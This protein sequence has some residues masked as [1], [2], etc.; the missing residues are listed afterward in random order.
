MRLYPKWLVSHET[1]LRLSAE[2]WMV[3]PDGAC[4][5]SYLVD[6]EGARRIFNVECV[7]R[8]CTGLTG[9]ALLS[10]IVASREL[11]DSDIPVW[12]LAIVLLYTV[13]RDR[14][15]SLMSQASLRHFPKAVPDDALRLWQSR[16]DNAS[17]AGFTWFSGRFHAVAIGGGA[18]LFALHPQVYALPVLTA[19]VISFG[20]AGV[21]VEE[22]PKGGWGRDGLEELWTSPVR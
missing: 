18:A 5:V 7:W 3:F 13:A 9:L 19:L 21:P 12:C 2:A 14:A 10:L 4:G 16:R 1:V 20:S 8:V 11:S 15:R 6:R 17:A 22:R